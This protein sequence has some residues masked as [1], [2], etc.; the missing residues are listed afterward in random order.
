LLAPGAGGLACGVLTCITSRPASAPMKTELPAREE[1]YRLTRA[2][3]LR[4]KAARLERWATKVPRSFVTYA[5][6]VC[7]VLILATVAD[8]CLAAGMDFLFSVMVAC[9]LGVTGPLLLWVELG[10]RGSRYRQEAKALEAEHQIRY[11][12]LVAGEGD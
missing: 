5:W 12:A 8:Q 1:Y 2:R 11:G 7:P 9:S 10:Y 4:R 3:E 6:S